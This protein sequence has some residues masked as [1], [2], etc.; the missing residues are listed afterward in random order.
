MYLSGNKAILFMNEAQLKAIC[1]PTRL[2]LLGLLA[3][4]PL[5]NTEAYKKLNRLSQGVVYRESVFKALK[6]L[7]QAGLL[8]RSF[9]E[10]IGYK[11][12]INFNALKIGN[13][14]VLKAKS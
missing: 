14:L 7:T 10:K 13:K 12:E 5:T 2:K 6:K 11:Y 8:K 4:E 3:E 9:K 1:D